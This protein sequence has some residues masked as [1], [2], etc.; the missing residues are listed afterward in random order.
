MTIMKNKIISLLGAL[1]FMFQTATAQSNSQAEKIISDLLSSVKTNAIKTDF[2]LTISD[3][4]NPKGQTASGTFTLKASKFVLDMAE[5][6]AWFD[7]KTQWAYIPQ[8][9]E[10]SITEPTENELSETNPMAILSGYNAKSIIRFSKIKSAQNYCIEMIPKV[11]SSDISKIEVQVNK[12][13]QNL[14]LIKLTNKNGSTSL[15]SLSN[16]QK[17]IKVPDSFFVFNPTKFKGLTENDLR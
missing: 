15:L 10:V 6:K 17:G 3:K 5:M 9:N 4:N 13:T 1:L 11:K 12:S 14:F 8:N 16:F 2:R 7:G